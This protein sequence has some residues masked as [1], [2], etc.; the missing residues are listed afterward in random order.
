MNRRASFP[1]GGAEICPQMVWA[2]MRDG[3][4]GL[5]EKKDPLGQK[6]PGRLGGQP[7]AGAGAGLLPEAPGTSS[8]PV[9]AST[10]RTSV[11]GAGNRTC[12]GTSK[13]YQLCRVQVRPHPSGTGPGRS[14]GFS[15]GT[16]GAAPYVLLKRRVVRGP[17]PKHTSCIKSDLGGAQ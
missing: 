8:E 14:P 17:G 7:R 3:M 13:R 9:F 12:T 10:R 15:L 16:P 2:P 5:S 1:R 4:V 11:T 6:K